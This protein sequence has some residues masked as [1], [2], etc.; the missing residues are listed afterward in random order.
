MPA[1]ALPELEALVQL[2]RR[3]RKELPDPARRAS[4]LRGIARQAGRALGGRP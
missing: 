1:A 4:I 2:R 3:L